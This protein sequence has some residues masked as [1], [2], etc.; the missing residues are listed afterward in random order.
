[1]LSYRST[2]FVTLKMCLHQLKK[3]CQRGSQTPVGRR[4]DP[5]TV[6]PRLHENKPINRLTFNTVSITLSDSQTAAGRLPLQEDGTRQVATSFCESS[7]RQPQHQP[8]PT[9]RHNQEDHRHSW[10]VRLPVK[11]TGQLHS[12]QS[13]TL[14][15]GSCNLKVRPG[16]KM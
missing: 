2:W 1:M 5:S 9:S 11:W 8:S 7:L 14:V 13:H 12:S 3:Y 10:Q 15:P 16:V 6:L 4:S